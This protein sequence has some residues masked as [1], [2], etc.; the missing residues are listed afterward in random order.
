MNAA[1]GILASSAAFPTPSR[2]SRTWSIIQ[3]K[4]SASPTTAGS[5]GA[6]AS[7]DHGGST[8]TVTCD[9]AQ[10]GAKRNPELIKDL[11][12][13]KL[14]LTRTR[15]RAV[16]GSSPSDSAAHATALDEVLA[17]RSLLTRTGVEKATGIA[18]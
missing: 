8:W 4:R 18:W 5:G 17:G 9:R 6:F 2:R 15:G 12:S 11:V 14:P 7:V 16:H 1:R 10:T 13:S 3:S